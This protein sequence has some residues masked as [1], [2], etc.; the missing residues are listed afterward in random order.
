MGQGLAACQPSPL[1]L[2]CQFVCKYR[3]GIAAEQERVQH[4]P[5]KELS[6][7]AVVERDI[8]VTR[9]SC[10]CGQGNLFCLSLGLA[11]LESSEESELSHL[12]PAL[13]RLES[14][15]ESWR[16]LQNGKNTYMEK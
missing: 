14:T 9:R 3:G 1:H 11:L 13:G 4:L 8:P 12:P 16:R 7:L 2:L 6:C 15:C 10:P 5:Q